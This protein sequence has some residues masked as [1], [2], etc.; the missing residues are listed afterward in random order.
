M[1]RFL[2][3]NLALLIPN[4]LIMGLGIWFVFAGLGVWM[5]WAGVVVFALMSLWAPPLLRKVDSWL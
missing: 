1:R 3:L 2:I 5:L 4:L